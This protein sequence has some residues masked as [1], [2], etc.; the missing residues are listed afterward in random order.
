MFFSEFY[1]ALI[2]WGYDLLQMKVRNK[3]V[4]ESIFPDFKEH[5]AA[6]LQDLCLRT[7]IVEVHDYDNRGE[8][9]GKD[10]QEKYEYFCKEIIK[11][12]EF[13]QRIFFQYPVL[14]QCTKK[15]VENMSAFYADIIECFLK[16]R[17]A[18]Q[19]AL[20]QGKEVQSI[21]GIKGGFSDVHNKGRC[22]V[23]VLLDN[24][25]EILY[26]P[27]SMDNEKRY[28]EMLRWLAVE[29]GIKQYEY[30]I[31]SYPDH[32]W[33]SIVGY[34]SCHSQRELERYYERL[35]VQ[36]FLTYLL[37][38]K[39]LHCENII[40]SGEYPV[41][42]DLETLTNIRYNRN[43]ITAND[44]IFYQLSQSVLYTGMLPFYHWNREGKG[45]NSS[46]ISGAEGQQY[47]FKLPMIIHGGT[48]DMRIVYRHPESVKNQNL[49][50]IDGEFQEPLLYLENLQKGF[51]AAY[52]A[53]MGKKKEFRFLLRKLENI[54]CRYLVADTQRYS[55]VLS[56][57]YHPELLRDDSDR[58]KF[59][60][61][62]W[63][64]RKE[65]EKEIVD[66]EVK[67]L[68]D[69]DIPYFYY[70]MNAKDLFDGQGKRMED[71][72]A[73]MP[74]ELLYLKLEKLC[75]E[76][77][78][79]QSGYI[80]LALELTA[81]K[82]ELFMNKVYCPK[83]YNAVKANR[84]AK[85]GGVKRNIEL[86]TER[87]LQ[88]AVWNR[89]HNEVSWCTVQFSNVNRK[90]WIIRSM[91]LYLYD[92]LSGMLLLM[93][94]LKDIDRRRKIAEIYESLKKQM[95]QYTDSGLLSLENLQ[96]RDPGMYEGEGSIVYT[97]LLLYKGGAENEYLDYAKRHARIVE[98]LIEED[99]KYDL[100]SGNAGA[101]QVLLMLYEVIPDKAYLETAEKAMDVLDK[102]SEKQK[103]GIGWTTEKGQP[104]MAGA[105]HGNSGVL[106]A[107]L[108]LWH[109]TSKDKYAQLA[110][111]VWAYE[112]DLYNP[113]I[114]NWTD[115]RSGQQDVDNIGA[116]AWCHGAP[117]V[118]Y[119]RIKGYEHV[120]DL[121]W[122]KRLE[123]DMWRAYR[124]LKEYW[125][126]DSWCLC[127]GICGNL[128]ILERASEI[129]GEEKAMCSDYPVWDEVHLLPQ[130]KENPGLLNGYGGI[131]L[132]LIQNQNAVLER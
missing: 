70:C 74:I 2:E 114:N 79:K 127:H 64:G 119:S 82:T 77:M 90:N 18:I 23:R 50:A 75:E 103:H 95:F 121:K 87:I 51:Q 101:V 14:C 59:L 73:C 42:I 115:V 111:E 65:D 128:W 35:G 76:D 9:R 48:S 113:E 41:L 109:L 69:G 66:S 25:E 85:T 78:K 110:E 99:T 30:T 80:E 38:T 92:G 89:E 28:S 102:A 6:R 72:F 61:S 104:P 58:E 93:Y 21:C 124:K 47:P 33:C 108:R 20:C 57:S 125:R 1:E 40:A 45:I 107:L 46:M 29:T 17:Q 8:L 13:I 112:E 126:R 117:G 34:A 27:R 105:A 91:N 62:M 94:H 81:D 37:G 39:D 100:L 63:K 55:M 49:A 4:L 10:S 120:K 56:A 123:K 129:L 52:H 22:V 86:L 26:K 3:N 16:D 36:L 68:S 131:L 15:A 83:E 60:Y 24:G 53:V 84:A 132:Y 106:T 5:L 118:L 122:K 67:A 44:E 98:R 11:K 88:N 31:L 71:F 43:R 130:E 7:L 116:M 96:T 19:S 12:E 32:S 97:Y 54:R